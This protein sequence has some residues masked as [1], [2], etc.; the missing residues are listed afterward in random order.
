[1]IIT[2]FLKST[3]L[4]CASV[5]LPS[6]KICSNVLKTSGWAFSTSSSKTT[7]KGFLLTASVNCPPSSYPTYPGGE[8]INLLTVCFSIYSDISIWINE[9]SSPNKNSARDFAVSVLPTPDGPKN[10]NDP[11]GL[12]GSF[13]P[14]LVLL[15]AFETA[16]IA[17]CWPTILLWSSFSISRSLA[18]SS[19]VNLCTG[20][21]VH[22]ANTSAI[23]S[24]S[25]TNSIS[26]ELEPSI[27]S[28][29][30]SN[31]FSWSLIWPAFSNNCDWTASIFCSLRFFNLSEISCFS[32]SN[33]FL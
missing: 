16:V 26:D 8:P 6:S 21:P 33:G 2:V 3:V 30:S 10:I 12:F 9:S 32:A 11:D 24:S 15:I 31:I 7:L 28:I 14:D 13:S 5:N 29:S 27:E 20:M 18:V 1:M 23:S 19:W 17:S 25:I 22:W 4:P